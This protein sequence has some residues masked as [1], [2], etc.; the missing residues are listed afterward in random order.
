MATAL[1]V[2]FIGEALRASASN[3]AAITAASSSFNLEDAAGVFGRLMP[4]LTACPTEALLVVPVM[5]AFMMPV[6]EEG[7][8]PHISMMPD[9][10]I[11]FDEEE[12]EDAVS[13]WEMPPCMRMLTH[14]GSIHNVHLSQAIEAASALQASLR[15]MS[16]ALNDFTRSWSRLDALRVRALYAE[17]RSGSER[18]QWESYLAWR[19]DE[20]W[21]A[22][23]ACV[24]GDRARGE[25]WE[26]R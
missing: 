23:L 14:P 5:V 10:F 1:L 13:K 6:R 20:R 15:G 2:F 22:S 8:F 3:S 7:S 19:V 16:L 26:M 4:P 12:E 21:V 9:M 18:C 24:D 17:P 25:R 11:L